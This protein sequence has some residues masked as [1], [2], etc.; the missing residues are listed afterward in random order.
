MTA[1]TPIYNLPYV[2][3]S[4][5]VANYPAVSEELAENVE[6]A[7]SGSGGMSLIT[8]QSFSAQATVSVN[9]CFTS[10]YENY[11]VI[12]TGRGGDSLDVH[13]R[14]RASGSDNTTANAYVI[15]R[16]R[17]SG[18]SATSARDTTTLWSSGAG[19]WRSTANVLN[20]A[21]IDFWRPA[22]AEPTSII[23]HDLDTGDG[24][25][26]EL[27]AATHNQSTAYDGFSLITSTSTITGT[28]WVYG[29]KKS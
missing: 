24:A 10:T 3:A 17:V 13:I 6:S 26:L 20:G 4:D 2:E 25:T 5:L 7:I 1:Y 8:T 18:T 29:Y 12:V 23:V 15:Q 16:L 14:L 21:A 9:N 19:I 22:L 11:R 27:K 28:L